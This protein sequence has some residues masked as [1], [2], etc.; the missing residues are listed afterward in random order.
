VRQLAD[1][2][3]E[4]RPDTKVLYMSG[5]TDSVALHLGAGAA[6][7]SFLQ[8][9]FTPSTLCEKVRSTLTARLSLAS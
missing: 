9:P 8:K 7:F 3:S 4:S 5:Y 6:T 2:L 1:K